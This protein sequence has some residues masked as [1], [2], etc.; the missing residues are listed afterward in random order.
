MADE[1]LGYALVGCGRFG[2]FCLNTYRTM[3]NMRLVAAADADRALSKATAEEF[4][5]TPLGSLQDV[6]RRDDVHLVHIATPPSTH[7]PFTRQ[8]L[9]AGKHVLCEKPLAI[10]GA[11]ADA[12]AQISRRTGRKVAVNFILRYS[13][14]VGMV[15]RILREKILGEPLHACFENYAQDEV[16]PGSHWFWD[17]SLSGGIFIE[18]GVHFFDLYRQWLGPGTV[19]WATALTRPGTH[20]EDRVMC[21]LEFGDALVT[22]YHGFDQPIRLDRQRHLILLERGDIVVNGWIPLEVQVHG[23]VDDTQR[24]ALA[25]AVPQGVLRTVKE[26][27]E[28]EQRF[29]SHG[30]EHYV[31]AEVFLDYAIRAP[32]MDIYGQLIGSLMQ[33]FANSI[34]T[35]QRTLVS[36]EDAVEAVKMAEAAENLARQRGSNL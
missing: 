15:Q 13:P 22:H 20:Q 14:I 10:S 8:C 34:R 18:H 26:Y 1:P 25:A 4:N 35:N 7:G 12:I 29:R 17:K 33:D 27:P 11:E 21:A 36:L 30:R 31:T 5:I 19:R 28:S 3:E 32:K 23:V 6:L 16:L 2:R 24:D 9:E